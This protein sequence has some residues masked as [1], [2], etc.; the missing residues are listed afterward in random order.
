MS[1]KN[2]SLEDIID[3]VEPDK[4]AILVIDMQNHYCS[5]KGVAAQKGRDV[6]RAAALSSRIVDFLNYCRQTQPKVHVIHIAMQHNPWTVSSVY[7]RVFSR[8]P[9]EQKRYMCITGTWDAEFFEEFPDLQPR[10]NEYMVAK[11]RYSGF[12]GTELDLI[13]RAHAITTLVVTGGDTNACVAGT[14]H[15]GFMRDYH[16][17]IPKDLV[18]SG[19][20]DLH[21]AALKNMQLYYGYVVTSTLIKDAWIQRKSLKESSVR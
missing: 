1:E 19:T 15:D 9:E 11:H 17:I 7:K 14:V 10:D 5:A 6:S 21:F 13:L 4:T 16:I 20:P 8:I 3:I 18:G 12:V 2:N